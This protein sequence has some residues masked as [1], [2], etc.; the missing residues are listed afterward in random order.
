MEHQQ[1]YD[2]ITDTKRDHLDPVV[3]LKPEVPVLRVSGP[4]HA[5]H[6]VPGHEHGLQGVPG[7]R[8]PVEHGRQQGEGEAGGGA[9]AGGPEDGAGHPP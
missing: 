4:G 8:P 6:P 2:D 7:P 5:L 9:G 1:Q 3:I